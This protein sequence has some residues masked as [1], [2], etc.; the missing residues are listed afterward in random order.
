MSD[1]QI[2]VYMVCT[3]EQDSKAVGEMLKRVSSAL[4][5]VDTFSDKMCEMD[6]NAP[7]LADVA[8]PAIERLVL[9]LMGLY[10]D[11]RQMAADYKA[12]GDFTVRTI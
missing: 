3:N 4:S 8:G 5:A 9:T 1:E 2:K 12:I 11:P 7:D 10:P 6:E